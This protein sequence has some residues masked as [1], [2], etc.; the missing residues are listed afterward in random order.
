MK[1]YINSTISDINHENYL[2]RFEIA[3]SPDTDIDT[4]EE[5]AL[6]DSPLVRFGVYSNPKAT[7]KIRMMLARFSINHTEYQIYCRGD[8]SDK[9]K[10]SNIVEQAIEEMA[11]CTSTPYVSIPTLSVARDTLSISGSFTT[12]NEGDYDSETVGYIRETL[13][14]SGY[15]VITAYLG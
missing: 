2:T 14:N 1:R 12:V 9:E 5:L 4:L 3:K 15:H 11:V 8:I 7:P 6:D 10:I 13:E